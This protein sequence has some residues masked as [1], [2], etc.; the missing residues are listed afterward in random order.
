MNSKTIVSILM[1]VVASLVM[2][3]AVQGQ[4]SSNKNHLRKANPNEIWVYYTQEDD[5]VGDYEQA[6][7]AALVQSRVKRK[8]GLNR[9]ETVLHV[10][11]ACMALSNE[12]NLVFNL[13]VYF[14][15]VELIDVEPD[16]LGIST[17]SLFS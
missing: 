17:N 6:M 2:T 4:T 11:L 16:G 7:E 12:Q 9:D 3:K 15:K 10:R 5:C 13:D 8:E 1:V 14:G